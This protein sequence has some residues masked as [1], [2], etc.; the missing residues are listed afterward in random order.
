M[1]KVIAVVAVTMGIMIGNP[2]PTAA[3]QRPICGDYGLP[4]DA[5]LSQIGTALD[6]NGN[7]IILIEYYVAGA[8]GELKVPFDTIAVTCAD[9]R[10]RA[11]VLRMQ[12][13]AV[14]VI[15]ASC[16][17]VG[18]LLAGRVQLP[19]D[20]GA[21]YDRKFAEEWYRKRCLGTK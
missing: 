21:H 4:K 18:D 2:R 6:A 3:L 15:Q 12:E 14:E 19:P 1:L 10:V 20:K 17:F 11:A 5:Q 9:V 16:K 13:F 7:K 8:T